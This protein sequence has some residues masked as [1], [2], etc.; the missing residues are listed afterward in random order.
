MYAKLL[1]VYAKG[2]CG[3][4]RRVYDLQ[5]VYVPEDKTWYIDMP[6][7]GD[8]Y[9]LAMVAGSNHLL[10][11]LDYKGE[12]RV[13]VLVRPSSKAISQLTNE[14]YFECEKQYFGLF[15]GATYKVHGLEGFSRDIWICPV[16]L[17]VLGYYPNYIYIKQVNNNGSNIIPEDRMSYKAIMGAKMNDFHLSVRL[18]N[19]LKEQDIETIGDLMYAVEDDVLKSVPL[20]SQG[21]LFDLM[22][23]LNLPWGT[24]EKKESSICKAKVI[25]RAICISFG[26]M[27]LEDDIEEW[28]KADEEFKVH[29]ER[30]EDLT[31]Y[32]KSER[33]FIKTKYRTFVIPERNYDNFFEDL[34]MAEEGYA[35]LS[36]EN[37]ILML[38]DSRKFVRRRKHVNGEPSGQ[39]P[40]DQKREYLSGTILHF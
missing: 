11:F 25:D 9:N 15:R 34:T 18:L 16:T 20:K 27:N 37:E 13:R 10:K 29:P 33:S 3:L 32:D 35:D 21:E 5:F 17:T 6:W 19:G 1:W 36:L 14:G 12:K 4:R 26:K 38:L 23:S 22:D 30:F 39:S 40:C 24:K 31:L 2:M 28:K 7:P 8:K